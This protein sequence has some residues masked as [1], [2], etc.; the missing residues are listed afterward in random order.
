MPYWESFPSVM[1]SIHGALARLLI[2]GQWAVPLIHAPR[3]ALATELIVVGLLLFMAGWTTL[4]A[5]RGKADHQLSFCAWLVLLP[6]LN[7]QSL[8]HNGVVLAVPLML[9][10]RMLSRTGQPW[11]RWLW[12][13]AAVLISVPKQTVWRLAPPPISPVEGLTV[14]ALPTWGAMLLFFVMVSLVRHTRRVTG[15]PTAPMSPT[16]TPELVEA[17]TASSDLGGGKTL[18]WRQT[19]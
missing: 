3:M 9:S 16:Q 19:D 12:G 5:K 15:S 1:F 10:A 2:G 17:T 13:M 14:V 7:P 4:Q 18:V 8:G 11:Q 6:M